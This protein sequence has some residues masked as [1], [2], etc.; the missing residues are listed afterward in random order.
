MEIDHNLQD[1]VRLTG[2]NRIESAIINQYLAESRR[3][4]IPYIEWGIFQDPVIDMV[5]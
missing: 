2:D 3:L 1:E 5:V 4:C